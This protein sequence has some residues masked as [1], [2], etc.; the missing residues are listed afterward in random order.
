MIDH[1]ERVL[2]SINRELSSFLLAFGGEIA[3][4]AA[5][6]HKRQAFELC[7]ADFRLRIDASSLGAYSSSAGTP[8]LPLV[9]WPAQLLANL[10]PPANRI[11]P[12][13]SWVQPEGL[14][15]PLLNVTD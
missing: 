2:I 14:A 5:G 11:W 8:P 1:D 6:Q 9:P 10:A 15:T 3:N 13:M 12:A 4:C 7:T